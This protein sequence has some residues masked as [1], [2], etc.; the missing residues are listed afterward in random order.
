V[1][2]SLPLFVFLSGTHDWQTYLGGESFAG[3][4]IPYFGMMICPK[5]MSAHYNM[6][7]ADAIL[8]SDLNIPLRG[9]AIGNGWMDGRNQYPA[10]L[11]YAAAY[12]I[13]DVQSQVHLNLLLSRAG[14]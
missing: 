12:G 3:Q 13:I 7:T 9:A 14:I 1:D 6:Y 10:Y 2:V 4:Y 11:E 8:T 5:S